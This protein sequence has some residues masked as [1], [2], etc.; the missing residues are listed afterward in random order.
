M[1]CSENSHQNSKSEENFS[2]RSGNKIEKV[3]PKYSFSKIPSGIKTPSPPQDN[4]PPVIPSWIIS[5]IPMGTSSKI[6][7]GGFFPIPPWDLSKIPEDTYA[8]TFYKSTYSAPTNYKIH[9]FNPY[10]TTYIKSHSDST[11]NPIPHLNLSNSKFCQQICSRIFND[12]QYPKELKRYDGINKHWR[13][14]K[15]KWTVA[16]SEGQCYF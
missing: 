12:K 9:L 2:I 10:Y 13:K 5:P 11:S 14:T 8:A 4:F 1:F 15:E 6:P 16:I 7:S 3:L